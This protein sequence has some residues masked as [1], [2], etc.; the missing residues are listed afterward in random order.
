MLSQN[1]LL[2]AISFYFTVTQ[3]GGSTHITMQP[4]PSTSGCP[5]NHPL[6]AS[7]LSPRGS[8]PEQPIHP[9]DSS[10]SGTQLVLPPGSPHSPE[11]VIPAP[12]SDSSL[13]PGTQLV[14]PHRRRNRGGRGGSCPPTFREGGA[15]P[16][17]NPGPNEV[18][19]QPDLSLF[20]IDTPRYWALPF[21]KHTPP[22]DDC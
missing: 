11:Q 6:R 1:Y 17:Q 22:M 16:P 19:N 14:L 2:N 13:S 18:T 8:T 7:D 5:P 12:P 3:S 15:L 21:N 9:S 20:M 10:T 4:N